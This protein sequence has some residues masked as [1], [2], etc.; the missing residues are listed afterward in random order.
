MKNIFFLICITIS[1]ISCKSRKIT[2]SP[3]TS[4]TYQTE[5]TVDEPRDSTSILPI[6]INPMNNMKDLGDPYKILTARIQDDKLWLE[7]SYGGGCK[8]HAF[9]MLFNKAYQEQNNKETGGS[10]L[11]SLSMKHEGNEDACRS[12]VRQNLRF[13]LTSIQNEGY[14]KLNIRLSSWEEVLVYSY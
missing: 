4:E 1:M 11:I 2:E 10:S 3:T 6:S 9:E 13:D 5:L 7:I 12:I 14:K 8:E